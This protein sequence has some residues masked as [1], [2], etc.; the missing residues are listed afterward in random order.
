MATLSISLGAQEKLERLYSYPNAPGSAESLADT[1]LHWTKQT[2]ARDGFA[3]Q[4]KIRVMGSDYFLDLDGP[5]EIAAYSERLPKFLEHGWDALSIIEALQKP[6]SKPDEPW[7]DWMNPPTANK[8]WDPQNTGTWRFFLPLGMAMANQKSLQFFH[9]P[10]IRLLDAM[11]DYLSDPVPVRLIELLMANGVASEQEAWLHSMVMD[12]APIAAPD[13]Q[14]TIYG[15]KGETVHLLP[16]SHFA[17]YQKAQV[18][19]LLN[20]VGKD[21]TIPIVVYGTP[22]RDTF[23][24]LYGVKLMT[25]QA[26]TVEIIPGRK[27]AVLCSGHPY[28]FYAQ[29]QKNVGSGSI[30]SDKCAAAAPTMIKDLVVARWQMEMGR[31]PTQDPGQ[32]L[33]S[34]NDYWKAPEQQSKVCE[35]VLH[36]GSLSYPDPNSLSFK[37]NLSSSDAAIRCF[38]QS[39]DPCAGGNA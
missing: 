7:P 12:G 31:N 34:C 39:N 16:I 5:P 32:V 14:G 29:V 27:T 9:Y 13:D 23:S 33:Q 21:Y 26:A 22:A 1:I 6:T 17:E 10:P 28:A 35:L 36:Q 15:P 37:F 4:A 18:S 38:K 25:N 24:Q 2:L 30:A 19:L 3:A 20:T 11:R 8:P